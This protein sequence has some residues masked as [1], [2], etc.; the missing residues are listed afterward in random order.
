MKRQRYERTD[1]PKG[2]PRATVLAIIALVLIVA[3]G[4][5]L[6]QALW[7][8]AKF[9]SVKGDADL[10]SSVSGTTELSS[11]DG[12]VVS[13]H[14]FENVLFLVVDD[15]DA[16]APVLS[17]ASIL[18]LDVTAGTGAYVILPTNVR[19]N[20][21]TNPQTL[22][23]LCAS[24][25]GSACV[26]AV[27]R[28]CGILIDHVVVADATGW[29]S[30]R[31]LDGVGAQELVSRMTNLLDHA[32]TDMDASAINDLNERVQAMGFSNI[33]QHDMRPGSEWTDGD[34]AV[35]I[36]VYNYEVAPAIGYL[37]P[38]EG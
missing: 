12:Y 24:A 20:P 23:D 21:E 17:D 35:W 6:F 2:G 13:D 3:G 22:S 25:G 18:S 1:V 36:V 19:V 10:V 29:E 9:D 16:E 5:L 33:T 8:R 7:A 28:R 32:R 4:Y 15:V 26:S 14:T 31:K 34:G 37:V 11:V 38:A 30:I 27:E